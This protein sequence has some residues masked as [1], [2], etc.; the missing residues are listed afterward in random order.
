[1]PPPGACQSHASLQCKVR[2]LEEKCRAQ[3][4]QFSLLSRDLQRFR[5][6]TGHIELLGGS[7]TACVDVPVTFNKP[8]P[9]FMNGLAPSIGTGEWRGSPPGLHSG[10]GPPLSV[11][12]VPGPILSPAWVSASVTLMAP[13]LGMVLSSTPQV[14]KATTL[15]G[16]MAESPGHS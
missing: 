2:E 1:M 10:L 3:S 12:G 5:Q 9:R 8:F 14:T 6:H 15:Q 7:P 4:E 11:P 13:V 16:H